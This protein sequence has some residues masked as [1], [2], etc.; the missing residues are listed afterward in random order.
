VLDPEERPPREFELPLGAGAVAGTPEISDS[1]FDDVPEEEPLEIEGEEEADPA[2]AFRRTLGM[3]ATGV[4]IITTQAGEQVHGMTANAFMSVSLRP[5]LVLISVDRRA[6]MNALLRD[7]VRFGVSVLAEDQRELS[8]RFAGRPGE[9][10]TETA[11]EIVHDTPVV[12][13]ALAQLVARTARSYWGGDHSLF[14]GQVEY[15]RYGGGAPLLFHGGRYEQLTGTGPLFSALSPDVLDRILALGDEQAF[16]SGE[17]IVRRGDRGEVLYVI[18]EGRVRVER[19]GR[20]LGALGAGDFFGE[21]AVFDG[22]PRSADV[23]AVTP[24][25]CLTISRDALRR[26]LELEPQVAWAMLQV[27]AA[28]LRDD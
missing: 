4:T 13:G 19:D 8:D 18:L 12:G 21:I 22:R 7:G 5:P 1:P 25:R 24:V 3:F 2:V 15:A 14:I 9:R 27:L 11:F 10:E 23:V 16:P 20:S 26:T 6:K 17:T 28:R